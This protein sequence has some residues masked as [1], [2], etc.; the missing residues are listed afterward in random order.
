ME[1][2]NIGAKA[3]S[4]DHNAENLS[5]TFPYIC[6]VI[7]EQIIKIITTMKNLLIA[8]A[9]VLTSTFAFAGNNDNEAA[10][11][12]SFFRVIGNAN[13]ETYKVLY[14][15]NM[16]SKVSVSIYNEAGVLVAKTTVKDK[17]GFLKPFRFES[18][19]AGE[20]TVVVKDGFGVTRKT[21]THTPAH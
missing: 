1:G 11:G 7:N 4:K 8:F 13:A 20:Y 12:K 10:K 9:L 21:F 6:N 18:M 19:P 15:A 14:M 5:K 17:D 3:I 2:L 16:D